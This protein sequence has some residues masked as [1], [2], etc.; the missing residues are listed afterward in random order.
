MFPLKLLFLC[1][2]PRQCPLTHVPTSGR[3]VALGLAQ[4]RVP[5]GRRANQ[6]ARGFCY[7]LSRAHKHASQ[8]AAGTVG[9]ARRGAWALVPTLPATPWASHFTSLKQG[10]FAL[11][12]LPRFFHNC[13]LPC[14]GMK[15]NSQGDVEGNEQETGLESHCP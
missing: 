7:G 14:V 9:G 12:A 4:C 8:E 5:A 13:L 6:A 15:G 3:C 10:V 11:P 2:R 1:A